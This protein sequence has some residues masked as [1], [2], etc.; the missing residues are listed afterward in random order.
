MIMKYELKLNQKNV[1]KL[2]HNVFKLKLNAIETLNNNNN[3]KILPAN[4]GK[5]TVTLD[6]DFYDSKIKYNITQGLYT[7]MS[8]D[9]TNSVENKMYRMFHHS[10]SPRFYEGQMFM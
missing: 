7:K 2:K 9:P 4:K 10:K 5:A 6:K 1:I 3:I 8:N